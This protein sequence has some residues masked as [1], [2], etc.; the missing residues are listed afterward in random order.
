MWGSGV[1]QSGRVL[2]LVGVLLRGEVAAGTASGPLRKLPH[3]AA[4]R[5]PSEVRW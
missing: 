4:V 5:L 2:L 3:N 1:D